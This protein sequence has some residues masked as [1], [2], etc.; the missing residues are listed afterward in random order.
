MRKK[1]IITNLRSV[2]GKKKFSLSAPK[3]MYRKMYGE[4]GC[5]CW[6]VKDYCT[7]Q[8]TC[9]SSGFKPSLSGMGLKR[10]GGAG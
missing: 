5:Q 4:F 8:S 1:E 3:E 9:T 10:H 2:E 6:G 7:G